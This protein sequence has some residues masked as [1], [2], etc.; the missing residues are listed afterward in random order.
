MHEKFKAL[1]LDINRFKCREYILEQ[2]EQTDV[3]ENI[4][5]PTLTEIGDGWQQGIYS[6]SQ[7]YMSSVICE[8]IAEELFEHDVE[9]K[10]QKI[11]IG[12]V[13]FDDYH[14]FGK[15]LVTL[16]LRASGY[17]VEDFGMI[18]SED[19]LIEKIK[20]HQTDVLLMSVLMLP[21][22]LKIPALKPKLLEANPHLKLI[23][24]GAPFRFDKELYKQIGADATGDTPRDALKIIEELEASVWNLSKEF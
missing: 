2:K 13:T 3:V 14:S 21:P 1:V 24:G 4:I 23:V 19:E 17:I 20:K 6:L 5:V 18:F 9:S 16:T 8:E 22:A 7:V 12:V 10:K 15:K 11:N